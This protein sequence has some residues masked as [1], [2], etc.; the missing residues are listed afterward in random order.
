MKIVTKILL[1]VIASITIVMGVVSYL[2]VHQI[3]K[4]LHQ[5]IDYLLANNL[6]FSE[7]KILESAESIRRTTEIVARRPEISKA[8][9]LQLSRGINQ[10]LNEIVIIYPFY[11][12]VLIVEPDGVIFAASTMDN[13]G[14][15]IAGEQLLGRN[16]RENPLFSEPSLNA[17]IMG[18]PG[19]DHF[20][21]LIEI[22][23]GMS[24]WFITPVRKSDKLIGWVVISYNWQNEMFNLLVEITEQL[25]KVGTPIV[26]AI[27]AD[28]SGKIVVGSKP[29]GEK[30]VPSPDQLWHE[31]QLT[32]GKTT[33]R[34]IIS[35]NK[36]LIY[37]PI[38]QTRNLF[39][40]IICIQR[41]F[42]SFR[43][44][45]HFTEGPFRKTGSATHRYTR[46]C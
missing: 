6:E 34:M 26:E 21:S 8:L 24:Q 36:S 22:N 31:K 42:V 10:V 5:Q 32:F 35:N 28:E 4:M 41:P 15:K 16:F 38:V 19:H 7:I 29:A 3:E 23:R 17:T 27:L 39:L 30:F 40:L 20:L 2:S 37:Q 12:Y 11:N 44:L 1:L 18:N 25:T 14:N 13:Q 33:M 45:L 46:T 9:F 43:P